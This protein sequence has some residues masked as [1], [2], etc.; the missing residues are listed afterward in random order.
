MPLESDALTLS[1]ASITRA[2]GTTAGPRKRRCRINALPRVIDSDAGNEAD[3]DLARQRQWGARREARALLHELRD[4][5]NQSG[6]WLLIAAAASGEESARLT[7][8]TIFDAI[9]ERRD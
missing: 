5:P 4:A 2:F 7:W 9:L 6:R 8:E 3:P 1:F